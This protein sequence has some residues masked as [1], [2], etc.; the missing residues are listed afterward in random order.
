[1][2][3]IGTVYFAWEQNPGRGPT[4]VVKTRH[5]APG[6]ISTIRR[7]VAAIDPQLPVFRDRSMQEWIDLQLVGRRVPL[8]IAIAF[9]VVALLLSVIGIYGVLAH[10]VAERRRELGVR[11][12]LGG[13][14]GSVFGLVLGEGAKIIGV[15]LALGFGGAYW[16]GR[17]I[18]SQLFDVAPMNPAVLAIV[19]V[20]LSVAALA[21]C[22]VPAW[23]ASRINPI[24]VLSR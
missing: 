11:L 19:A 17:V 5:A 10:S 18:E 3:P 24:V 8:L 9:G 4:L 1:V 15:G 20:V 7:E 6:L 23:R 21:A 14:T 13:S 22:S 2:T 16:V 12:A